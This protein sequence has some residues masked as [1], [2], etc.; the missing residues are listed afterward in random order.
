MARFILTLIVGLALLMWAASGVVQTTARE[1]F[2]RDVSSRAQL[3]LT[4]AA[5]S[6]ADAWYNPKDLEKQ[7]VA[8]ARDERVMGAAACGSDLSPLSSTPGFPEEFSCLAVGPR[9]RAAEVNAD[10][11]EQQFHEWSTVATLPTGR[12][13]VSA[14]PIS[15]QG[16]QQGFAILVHDLS[17][18]ERREAA[19][20][21]FLIVVFGI[22]AVMAF[23]IPMLVAKRARHD[24]SLELRN[25][26]RGVGKQSREF[27]PIL[28]DMRELVGQMANDREDAPGQWTAERLKQ[29]LN[30]HLHGEKIVILANREPYIHQY[31]ADGGIEI[32]H[33]ASGLVTALE[34]VM[35]ACSG[36]WIA[37]GSGNAD[38]ETVDRHDH[39][40]VPPGEESYHIRRVWLSEEEQQGY[41]YGFSNEGLW[42]LCHVA[43][44]RP[45]FRAEDWR[46]YRAV[47]QKFADAV[48]SEVDSKDPIVL[49]QDYH[50]ALAPAMIR[51]RL[52]AATVIV[53]WHIPWPNAERMGICPWRNELLE[54]LLGSS[55][56][57]F[58]TQLHCNNFLDSV[59]RYMETRIDREQNAVVM[60]GRRTLIRPYPIA[61]EWP[62]RWVETSPSPEECR[63]QVWR[64]FGLK[65][66][67]LLGVG[68]DRLDYTKGVEERL[69]AIE[70]LLER[71]PEFCGRLSF[72]QLAAPSRTKIERYGELNETVER[73][74]E[75]INQR[76]GKGD[77]KP[78]IL[79]RSH[80]EPPEVFRFFRAADLCYVSSLHDGMNL[81]AKEFVA[82]RTDLKGVLVLSEFT[83]AAR[84]LTEALIVNPYDLEASSDALAAALKMPVEEQQDRMR[85]MRSLL[86][87]FNVYRWA[88]KMLVDAARLRNQERVAGRLSERS[89]ASSAV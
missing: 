74:A 83:G 61:L 56:L 8:I 71:Y 70:L 32:Q 45:V 46:Q 10:N 88:G 59:D 79:L 68:V 47:N 50:F 23:G 41:Y 29:T 39:V 49:V 51:K 67:A 64:E 89:S 75:R 13:H 87:Q 43:H 22:L 24:W 84:E 57:G 11:V 60:Q 37:H 78:I 48:C 27:Q 44:A 40:Q 20:R 63:A 65:S 38:R 66:N 54:G 21:A 1:W 76:F 35:R 33:P 55:I 62:V 3:V 82:A 81:V 28:S 15:N 2:E 19:A 7:L 4:G 17:Y 36:V 31:T 5:Q 26:L 6:L 73:L 85:S 58:H 34:P 9:I 53:F 52:P 72:A 16:Q 18:I 69:L 14:M 80:H 42:P 30:R 77:Y 25:L 12:V 86:V